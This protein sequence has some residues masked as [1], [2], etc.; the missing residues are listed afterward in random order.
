[1][2]IEMEFNPQSQSSC[3]VIELL[4]PSAENSATFRRKL[5]EEK[6]LEVT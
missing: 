2:K 4:Q 1:M 5:E 3:H 6:L